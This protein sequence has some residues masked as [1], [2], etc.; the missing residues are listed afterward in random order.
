MEAQD[1]LT[2]RAMTE[3]D[4]EWQTDVPAGFNAY[5]DDERK[6]AYYHNEAGLLHNPRCALRPQRREGGGGAGERTHDNLL[7]APRRSPT[8][9]CGRSP[10]SLQLRNAA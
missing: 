9:A 10:R 7:C 6:L 3:A 8:R 2:P 4:T 1:L 5:W